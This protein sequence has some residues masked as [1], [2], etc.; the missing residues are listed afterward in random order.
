MKLQRFDIGGEI[1]S[2][3]TRGMYPDPRDAVREYIQNSIDAKASIVDVKIR[4]DSIVIQDN[5]GGM[6]HEMLRKAV[7][8]GVSEKNP[9]K[10]VGFM[11]IGIYSAFHLC[12]K[13]DIYTRGSENIPNKLSM[14][15]GAM[16]E[17]L[18]EQKLKRINNNIGSDEIIGLQTLLEKTIEI[19]ENESINSSEFPSKGTRIEMTG[20]SSVFLPYITHFDPLA[21]YLREVIPLHFDSKFSHGEQIEREI[22]EICQ[23]HSADFD[24]ITL[25]LQAGGRNETLFRP[26][27]NI[28]FNSRIIPQA[29]T[30][31]PIESNGIFLGVVWG[32]LNS[33]R[34]VVDTKELRGFILKK[35]GFSIGKRE[36]LIKYFPRGNTF[37]SRYIGEVIIT[38]PELLPNASRND[39]EFS[40]LRTLFFEAFTD[41]ADK[42]DEKGHEFQEWTKADEELSKIT[43]DLKKLNAD[44]FRSGNTTEK[45]V[46]ILVKVKNEYDKIDKRIKRNALSPNSV[47]NANTIR[48]EA[49]KLE[50]LIQEKI[51]AIIEQKRSRETKEV[52]K[53]KSLEIAETLTDLPINQQEKEAN[54]ES[55]LDLLSEFDLTIESDIL[56]FVLNW[57][58]ERY[59]AGEAANKKDYYAKLN[60]LKTEIAKFEELM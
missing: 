32:C 39:L 20:L 50:A 8:V 34:K 7:R 12:D 54:Y 45:L 37:F 49:Q 56:R 25:N 30:V 44:F 57:I 13:L 41:V 9:S 26:Y 27:K 17:I 55:L 3:I 58:D 2:I 23:L 36:N 59:I 29:P 35:Q 15:F 40:N 4:Q 46:D 6:N 28:D 14:N 19:S 1:I 16:K 38:H 47:T 5:G 11:G 52:I 18:S 60:E 42:L 51:S 24:L 31:I 43:T 53:E 48:N 22:H 21:E 10:D 33:L